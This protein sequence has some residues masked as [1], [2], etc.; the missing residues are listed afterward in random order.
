MTN[1]I[2]IAV[3]SAGLFGWAALSTHAH[4]HPHVFAEARLDVVSTDDGLLDEL[5]HVWRFDELFTSTVIFEFDTNS[6]NELDGGE[7]AEVANVVTNSIADFN[8]FQS[9]S[10][11][12]EEFEIAPVNDLVVDVVDGQLIMIFTSRTSLPVSMAD[13]PSFSIYDP[14]F[15]TSIEFYTDGDM[16]MVNAP[17]G[18]GFDKVIPDPEEAIA[19]NQQ[20]LTD[21]WFTDPEGNDLSRIFA[22][23]MEVTCASEG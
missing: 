13:N 21:A 18:C 5:R 23:R 15:Y 14:T 9:V 6:D 16:Q 1:R 4:A 20:S 19:Q 17:S 7:L 22:T 2:C 8:Y 11:G 10:V 12:G 3:A